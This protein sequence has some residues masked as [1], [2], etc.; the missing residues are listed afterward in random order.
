MYSTLLCIRLTHWIVPIQTLRSTHPLLSLHDFCSNG[1]WTCQSKWII[2]AVDLGEN[3]SLC[4]LRRN[5][6]ISWLGSM[7]GSVCSFLFRPEKFNATL[8]KKWGYF[9]CAISAV[10]LNATVALVPDG[11]SPIE[12]H[13]MTQVSS[14]FLSSMSLH[15]NRC[16]C[17]SSW[18]VSTEWYIFF[19]VAHQ[20]HLMF[21]K[22]YQHTQKAAH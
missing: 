16:V 18:V 11:L 7:S 9:S 2:D 8:K 5:L 13:C 1:E 14:S 22:S 20:R 3:H 6:S 12:N 21:S 15:R 19:Y 17:C 10:F 4:Q